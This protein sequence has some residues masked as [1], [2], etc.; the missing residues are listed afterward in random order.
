MQL[1]LIYEI[2]NMAGLYNVEHTA[3]IVGSDVLIN[4]GVSM[5]L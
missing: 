3:I 1:Q 5:S 2:S 4:Q